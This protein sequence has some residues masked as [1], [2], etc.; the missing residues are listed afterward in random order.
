M[1][2]KEK[3]TNSEKFRDV[4]NGLFATELWVM[5]EKEFLKWLNEEYGSQDNG[6]RGNKD[7]ETY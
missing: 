2:T 1:K 7:G 4:F 6:N 3:M 5:S